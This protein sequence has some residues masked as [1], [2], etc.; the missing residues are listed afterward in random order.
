MSSRKYL[1]VDEKKQLNSAIE[2]G[3][4]TRDKEW[5]GKLAREIKIEPF[6]IE[7]YIY[8]MKRQKD[9][10]VCKLP[11]KR[12]SGWDEFRAMQKQG[13]DEDN[14]SFLRRISQEWK[15][16]DHVTKVEMDRKAQ[17]KNKQPFYGL[18]DSDIVKGLKKRLKL[19]VK[20]MEKANVKFIGVSSYFD[21]INKVEVF[22]TMNAKH[23]KKDIIDLVCKDPLQSCTKSVRLRQLVM[24]I[25]QE[26]W[27]SCMKLNTQVPYFSSNITVTGLPTGIPFKHPQLY[28][29]NELNQIIAEDK[30]NIQ[31]AITL[32]TMDY[33]CLLSSLESLKVLSKNFRGRVLIEDESKKLQYPEKE[34][35][36]FKDCEIQVLELDLNEA[37]AGIV[38]AAD[39]SS[40][41]TEQTEI[42]E[43]EI[44]SILSINQDKSIALTQAQI[45]NVVP[46]T[47][48]YIKMGKKKRY[49][50]LQKAEILT[51]SETIG[52]KRTAE[53]YNVSEIAPKFLIMDVEVWILKVVSV[54]DSITKTTVN[55]Y[56]C[57]EF[58]ATNLCCRKFVATNLWYPHLQLQ[59]VC[60]YKPVLQKV[61]SYKPVVS[62][63][64]TSLQKVCSYKPVVSTPSARG[65]F[66]ATNMWYPHLQL[67]KVCSYKPVVSTP[68]ARGKFV[69][70]NLW[71]RHLQL[72][73]LQKV[74][75]YKPVVSTPSAA[76]SL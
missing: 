5:I 1:T 63:P 28:T 4:T 52:V 25:F 11:R 2:N 71:Y 58:E 45:E 69:A 9:N 49:S 31:M 7:K 39:E 56:N 29:V 20:D 6:R 27:E 36:S 59:K 42:T 35:S 47:P 46:E 10:S 70:T 57:G 51:Q 26:R 40:T 38:L 15:L 3:M 34:E 60:S 48:T 17:E 76:E 55:T 72:Q 19:L 12:R 18:E 74:C 41:N 33:D 54:N 67:Q 30:Y 14:R 61:C 13:A 75:S 21:P 65:K 37:V 68:S 53:K 22:H 32:K 16:L 23:L 24:E 66:V 43:L 62:T 8:N 44:P 64:L 50:V 73:K